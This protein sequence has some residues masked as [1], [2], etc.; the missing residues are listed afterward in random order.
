MACLPTQRRLFYPPAIRLEILELS[1]PRGWSLRQTAD[2]FL[3]TAA[4][5]RSWM[6]RL[7][8]TGPKALVQLRS[9]F[10]TFPKFVRY[11]VQQLQAMC[12][13]LDKKLLAEIPA[14]AGLHLRVSTVDRFRKGKP[15]PACSLPEATASPT[16]ILPANKSNHVWHVDLTVIPTQAGFWCRSQRS[17]RV[18]DSRTRFC[19]R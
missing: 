10:S 1:A 11:T 5:I 4:T 9:P 6:N 7:E 8:E 19:P 17:G 16:R 3:A 2:I 14:C 18:F 15:Q 13:P 12:P